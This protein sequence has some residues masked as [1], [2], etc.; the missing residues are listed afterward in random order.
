MDI[1]TEQN[2]AQEVIDKLKPFCTGI[3]CAGGAPRDWYF[4]NTCNDID[5]Y[6]SIP[7]EYS[8]RYKTMMLL[9]LIAPEFVIDEEISWESG[10]HEQYASMGGMIRVLNMYYKGKKVQL[11][12]MIQG[13]RESV[14]DEMD[15]SICK[16][17][18]DKDL[19]FNLHW[20]FKLGEITN[21]IIFTER[22]VTGTLHYEK[23]AQRFPDRECMSKEVAVNRV[24]NQVFCNHFATKGLSE[25][26][27]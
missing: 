26:D 10:R 14:L 18:W 15:V 16:I 7:E 13:D 3:V 23:M 24:I 20:D 12:Q 25:N 22:S 21:S 9:K 11:I 27:A 8:K 4:G 5:I 2:I 1:Y 19:G 17:A 6:F